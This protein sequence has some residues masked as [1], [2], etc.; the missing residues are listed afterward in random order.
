M[1]AGERKNYSLNYKRRVVTTLL[2]KY[3]G[4]VDDLIKKA[5]GKYPICNKCLSKKLLFT[6]R[7]TKQSGTTDNNGIPKL[8]RKYTVIPESIL[9]RQYKKSLFPQGVRIINGGMRFFTFHI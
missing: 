4:N 6:E 8:C 3:A 9:L 1:D 7:S 2:E 5:D